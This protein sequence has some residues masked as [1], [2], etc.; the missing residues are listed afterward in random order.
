M[1]ESPVEAEQDASEYSGAEKFP[2]GLHPASLA[3]LR[4]PWRP[5]RS[6]NP[7][8]KTKDGKNPQ[9]HAIEARLLAK[10]AQPTAKGSEKTW[11]QRIVDGWVKAAAKGDAQARRD[12]LERLYP[13]IEQDKGAGRVILEGLKLELTPSGGAS[14]TMMRSDAVSSSSESHG[15]APAPGLSGTHALG[16]EPYTTPLLEPSQESPSP[17]TP[18]SAQKFGVECVGAAKVSGGGREAVLGLPGDAG[19]GGAVVLPGL[20]ERVGSSDGG[21]A[22]G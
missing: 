1:D 3:N 18:S 20:H 22:A 2:K 14:V 16:P 17:G 13:I 10:L 11:A 4:P 9:A 21:G 15:G 19:A 8:G 6:G 7:S 5:G 12:I